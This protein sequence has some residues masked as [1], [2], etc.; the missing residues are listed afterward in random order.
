[1]Y[2]VAPTYYDGQSLVLL[3]DLPSKQG[4]ALGK[5]IGNGNKISISVDGKSF[6]ECV[7]Y[8]D[9]ELWYRSYFQFDGNSLI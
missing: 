2:K 9:Y 1:M 7:K 8:E 5:W 6:H 3:S 4:N